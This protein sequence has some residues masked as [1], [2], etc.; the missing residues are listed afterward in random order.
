MIRPGLVRFALAILVVL[1]HITKFVFLG[2]FA[3]LCFFMLSG[4]WIAYM[5]NSKYKVAKKTFLPFYIS[6]LWRLLPVYML[7]NAL[8]FLVAVHYN[9][10]YTAEV[11]SYTKQ[12]SIVNQL[13]FW[14]S[15]VFILGFGLFSK[16]VLSPAWSLD[17]E[18][19]F[20]LLF[21]FLFYFLPKAKYYLPQVS[22]LLL[23][24]VGMVSMLSPDLFIS[25]TVIVYLP[26][27]LIGSVIY[28]G[29]IS[30]SKRTETLFN[31]SLILVLAINY[32]VPFLRDATV[33]HHLSDY[34]RYLNNYLPLL[35]IPLL[36]NSVRTGSRSIM[37]SLLG[38]VSYVLY[39]THWVVLIPYLYY[40]QGQNTTTKLLYS[41]TYLIVTLCSSYLIYT[42]YDKPIDKLRRKWT[43]SKESLQLA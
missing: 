25:K 5:Y 9:Y 32:A 26:Y 15:N 4:Y 17:V 18:L 6:R 21:P 19:Q 22:G 13:L 23:L 43:V 7:L 28:F 35:L 10:N 16:Q 27:F 3:V 36:S 29:D 24:A 2:H 38:N 31:I 37:D 14:L 33:Y 34:N 12:L 1:F 30:F 41:V 20:Y 39:L 8:A 11:A 40:M 42:F